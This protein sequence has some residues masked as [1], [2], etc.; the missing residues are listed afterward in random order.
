MR[1]LG[2]LLFRQPA[3]HVLTPIHDAAAEAKAV[4]PD[5]EMAPVAQRHHRRAE[6]RGR[7]DQGSSSGAV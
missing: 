2:L 5:A 1:G 3:V 7:L 6:Y 4:R